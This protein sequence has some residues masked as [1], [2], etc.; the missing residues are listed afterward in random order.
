MNEENATAKPRNRMSLSA[1][2][3]TNT[4]G[5]KMRSANSCGINSLSALTS[6]NHGI[7]ADRR[8][9]GFSSKN[10]CQIAENGITIP[11]FVGDFYLLVICEVGVS[12]DTPLLQSRPIGLP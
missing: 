8:P 3:K 12:A 9:P 11:H 1:P 5:D 7:L 10:S 4:I 2:R 6:K